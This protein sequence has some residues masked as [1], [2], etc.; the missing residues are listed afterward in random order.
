MVVVATGSEEQGPGV[1]SRR[2]IEA[3]R[4]SIEGVGARDVAVG[5]VVTLNSAKNEKLAS[6]NVV[7]SSPA[8]APVK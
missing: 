5:A 7:A 2:A 4:L 8:F 3:D 1:A 6:S